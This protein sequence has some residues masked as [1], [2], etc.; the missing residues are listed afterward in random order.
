[1]AFN[2]VVSLEHLHLQLATGLCW[3]P[4]PALDACHTLLCCACRLRQCSPLSTQWQP[5][6]VHTENWCLLGQ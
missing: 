2:P 6:Q 3:Q 5:S 4:S 1:M